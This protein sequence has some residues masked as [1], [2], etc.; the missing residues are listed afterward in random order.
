VTLGILTDEQIAE[1]AK[2]VNAASLGPWEAPESLGLVLT[3]RNN[4]TIAD[5]VSANDAEFIAH[6]RDDI[7]A[8]LMA[9]REARLQIGAARA[10]VEAS[11]PLRNPDHSVDEDGFHFGGIKCETCQAE[12]VYDAALAAYRARE[13]KGKP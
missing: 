11:I 9:L 4:W 7:P 1:I 10:V 3:T 5:G 2:R 13:A 12:K 6:A 8:L